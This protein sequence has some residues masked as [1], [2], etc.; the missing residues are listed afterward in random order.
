MSAPTENAPGPT[1]RIARLIMGHFAAECVHAV[2]VFGVADLLANWHATIE[3]LASATGCHG[4]SLQ[5]VLRILV[6]FG[7]FTEIAP[8]QFQLTP[9]GATL[10]S[11]AP[12]SLRDTAIFVLSPPLWADRALKSEAGNNL[13]L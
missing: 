7:L 3:G 4:P 12:D 9:V 2:A 6:R 10:R 13:R 8:G 5:R 11:D 1:Q